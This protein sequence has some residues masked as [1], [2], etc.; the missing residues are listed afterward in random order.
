MAKNM[1]AEHYNEA[2]Y[3][4]QV[5]GSVSSAEVILGLLYDF[6][7]PQ[8]VIDVGCGRGA[9]LSVAESL[10][11][12]TLI[13][14]DGRWNT[15]DKLLS[16]NIDFTSVDLEGPIDIRGKYDL[17]ISLEV[18]E[19]LASKRAKAFV[20]ILCKASNVVLFSAA[21]VNQGGENHINEQWQSY[22]IELFQANGYEYFDIFRGVI[23]ENEKVDWWY[24]QNVF[25]FINISEIG[26][27]IN[28]EKLKGMEEKIPNIVHPN[29]Y[30]Y[31]Y[32]YCRN[33][34][35]KLRACEKM[36]HEPTLRFCV[37]SLKRCLFKAAK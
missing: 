9:W 18:A 27:Q 36:I 23:W 8:S 20:E 11:T 24:R 37:R 5:A 15:K 29:Y 31:I 4:R 3:D 2:F 17:C 12:K 33:N 14:L 21:I 10:G 25:L 34:E 28:M 26:D 35:A 1:L 7:Q 30:E 13:G 22:W 6:Y 32:Q 16:Q 19:H